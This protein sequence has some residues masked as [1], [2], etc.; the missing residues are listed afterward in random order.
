M[1]E[2]K[3]A[4]V[5]GAS[6][7]VGSNLVKELNNNPGYGQIIVVVRTPLTFPSPKVREVPLAKF[8]SI[9]IADHQISSVHVFCCLG[10]TI[11]KAGTQEEFRKVDY[12]LPLKIATWAK[13]YGI[14]TIAVVSSIGANAK[15]N[16]FYLRTKGELEDSLKGLQFQNIVIVRP[17]L[18]LGTRN[19]FRLGEE[20]AKI[21]SGVLKLL[22]WG[23]LK[24]Y[25]PIEANKVAKAMMRLVSSN[26]KDMV[27]ESDRLENIAAAK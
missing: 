24:K 27:F 10:T 20:F 19:E 6:G 12:E 22:L 23:P 8:D 13:T 25:R 5:F 14:E 1:A 18:L 15:S 7:L 17:S 3:V 16:N 11:K 4:I 9:D 21:F 26:Q 2:G